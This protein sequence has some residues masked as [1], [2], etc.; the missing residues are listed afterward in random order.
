MRFR[1]LLSSC[2]AAG[3]LAFTPAQAETWRATFDR[4]A[5]VQHREAGGDRPYF[6][7]LQFRSKFSVPG[8]TNVIANVHEPHDWVSKPNLRPTRGGDHM[9]AGESAR[10]PFW[11]RTIEWRDVDIVPSATVAELFANPPLFTRTSRSEVLGYVIVSFDNN[12]TPPHVVRGLGID[13]QRVLQQTL[14]EKVERGLAL[15]ALNPNFAQQVQTRLFELALAQL[16]PE[17]FLELLVQATIGSTFNPD[18]ITGVQIRVFSAVQGVPDQSSSIRASLPT[19]PVRIDTT[20]GSLTPRTQTLEFEGTGARYTSSSVV[21]GE[22]CTATPLR[23]LTFDFLS[24]DDGLRGDSSIN[25]VVEARG[26]AP[27]TLSLGGGD[28]DR[29]LSA[30]TRS[31]LLP[32]A[33]PRSDIQRIRVNYVN[34]APD[35]SRDNWTLKALTISA[36][37]SLLTARNGQPLA[38]FE[39]SSPSFAADVSCELPA[40]GAGVATGAFVALDFTIRTGGDDLRGGNDN[41]F[42]IA[43]LRDGRRLEAPFNGRDRLPNGSQRTARLNL[44][45]GVTAADL[46]ALGVR[47][48]LGGGIGGDNWNVDALSVSGVAASGALTSVMARSGGPLVRLTGDRREALFGP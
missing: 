39:G 14:Q 26:R 21:Q 2:I 7:I 40:S 36:G 22:T 15:N 46:A 25:A 42:V 10:L 20:V 48:T 8:S 30:F 19:G 38:R 44:P 28:D 24:G 34:R 5:V 13:F 31:A 12:N 32:V 29:R 18:H 27:I 43:V 45:P 17:R 35:F 23:R 4:V 47:A 11:S 37:A 16:T 3:M 6:V 33:I 41:A 1:A 9:R